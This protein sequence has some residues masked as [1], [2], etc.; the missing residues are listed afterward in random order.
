MSSLPDVIRI[1]DVSSGKIDPVLIFNELDRLKAQINLLRGDMA[2]FVKAIATIP[3]GSSP[4]DYQ[5]EIYAQ[6]KQLQQ[7]IAS[8]CAEYNKLLPIINLSQIRLG[9]DVEIVPASSKDTNTPGFTQNSA[10]PT[11]NGISELSSSKAGVTEQ[12]SPVTR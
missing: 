3:Q 1:D 4:T 9:H 7:H 8:Y 10:L 11:A 12:V 2:S 6:L 5:R